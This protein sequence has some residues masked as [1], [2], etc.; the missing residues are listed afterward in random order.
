[1][2]APAAGRAVPAFFV[3]SWPSNVPHFAAVDAWDYGVRDVGD[4][5]GKAK[6]VEFVCSAGHVKH[7]DVAKAKGAVIDC[8]DTVW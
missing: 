8:L 5:G 2:R 7:I 3:E 6:D 4:R 1:M